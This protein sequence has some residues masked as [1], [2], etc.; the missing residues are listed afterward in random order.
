MIF[1][2][3]ERDLRSCAAVCEELRAVA[4]AG[5]QSVS[6]GELVCSASLDRCEREGAP[7]TLGCWMQSGTGGAWPSLRPV[8]GL[9]EI[10]AFEESAAMAVQ[11]PYS[12]RP[13]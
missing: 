9:E 5:G 10:L 1:D 2:G 12:L 11:R 3:R 13:R 8:C 6:A 7:E 4:A